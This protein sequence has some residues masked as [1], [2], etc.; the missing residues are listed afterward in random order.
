MVNFHSIEKK[1]QKI[2]ETK[3]AFKTKETQNKYYVLEM[4][5]Y[6]SGY[7]IHMGHAENYSIGDV[8]ARFKRMQGF[9]ILYHMGYDSFGLPAENAAIKNKKHPKIFTETS[10]KN[11]IK[12]LEQWFLKITDYANEL[13]DLIDTLD[14]PE[15][16]KTMQK[17]W[18]GRSTGTL[19]EFPVKES[20]EKIPVFTTRI[21]TIYGVTFMV[22]APEHPIV[23]EL[24]KN[25]KH[26]EKVKKFINKVVLED[27]FERTAEDKEKEGLF[28][29]KHA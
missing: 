2:W 25:T 19:I 1:W 4:F 22:I 23:M 5:P 12:Q 29:G 7:G 6:P 26:E 15:R 13:L 27:K 8:Y 10:I 16:I 28:I 18:I 21:D 20:K 14:W 24:V 11:I 3:K 17:N 9:N